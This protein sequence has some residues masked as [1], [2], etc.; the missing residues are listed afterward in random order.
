MP[1]FCSAAGFLVRPLGGWLFGYLADHHGRSGA[2][3]P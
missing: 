2:F 3:M 1:R